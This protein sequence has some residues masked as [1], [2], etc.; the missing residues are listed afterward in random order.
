MS[1]FNGFNYYSKGERRGVVV[2][3][4]IITLLLIYVVF[5]KQFV[6]SQTLPPNAYQDLKKIYEND[7][8]SRIQENLSKAQYS[9]AKRFKFDPNVVTEKELVSMGLSPRQSQSILNYRTKGGKFFKPEDF[10]KMYTVSDEF[11]QSVKPYISIKSDVYK[12]QKRYN[13]TYR[14][15][16]F[17]KSKK[18]KIHVNLSL[19]TEQELKRVKGIGEKLAGRIV[20]YRDLLGGFYSTSQL[21]EVYGMSQ[22]NLKSILPQV[23]VDEGEVQLY[24][25]NSLEAKEL[26]RHPY[27]REW[28]HLNMILNERKLNGPYLNLEDLKS[29]CNAQQLQYIQKI[30]P[31]ISFK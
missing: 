1:F 21:S 29:R 9:N 24:D 28:D 23:F 22:E 30:A 26:A 3:I 18:E 8:L 15:R 27:I 13:K 16:S 12:S 2:L 11:Y 20:K 19:A 14:K 10:K 31:Y 25:I 5:Y 4:S 7:S 17:S 6:S